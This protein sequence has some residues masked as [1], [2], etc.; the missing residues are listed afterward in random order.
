MC[1]KSMKL[2]IKN[3]IGSM[4]TAKN[5]VLNWLLLKNCNSVG[6]MKLWWWCMCGGWS[7]G[8]NFG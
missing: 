2:K 1:K 8:R 7:T 4:T 5:E 6:A 3:G